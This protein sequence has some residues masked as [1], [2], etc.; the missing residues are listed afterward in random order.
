MFITAVCVLFLIEE[1]KASNNNDD[2]LL[3]YLQSCL[4]FSPLSS[5][6]SDTLLPLF[7]LRKNKMK[8]GTLHADY[9]TRNW[10]ESLVSVI[11]VI[12]YFFDPWTVQDSPPHLYDPPYKLKVC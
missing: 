12:S 10:N 2:F 9:V 6:F 1:I 5:C 4:F 11:S 8:N 3:L 7:S